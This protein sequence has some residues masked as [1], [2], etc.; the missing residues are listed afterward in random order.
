MHRRVPLIDKISRLT[1]YQP[2]YTLDE[3]LVSVIAYERN[4]LEPGQGDLVGLGQDF[5]S[6]SDSGDRRGSIG[7]NQ[8]RVLRDLPIHSYNGSAQVLLGNYG[9]KQTIIVEDF[10]HYPEL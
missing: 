9:N 6:Y 1:G 8:A 4:K 5:G 2:S 7:R 10:C 3:M